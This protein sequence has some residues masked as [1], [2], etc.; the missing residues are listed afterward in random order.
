MP[1]VIDVGNCGFDHGSLS[2]LLQQHFQTPCVGVAGGAELQRELMQGD[3]ALVIVNRVFDRD[4]GDGLGLIGQL[5]QNPETA[6]IPVMLLSNYSDAQ[7]KAVA[8]GALPG[9]GKGSLRS[10]ATRKLLADILQHG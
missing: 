9:F 8:L 10:D 1:R 2:G 5:K 7:A 3:V 4:G 6:N